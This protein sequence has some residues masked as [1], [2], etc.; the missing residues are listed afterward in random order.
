MASTIEHSEPST[1]FAAPANVVVVA[2][3]SAVAAYAVAAGAELA[4]IRVFQPTELELTWISDLI[5]AATLGTVTYLWLHLRATRATLSAI[6]RDKLVLD[7]QLSLA[8]DVQRKLLPEL[9]AETPV[10][11]WGA[12]LHPAGKVGGDFYDIVTLGD[13]TVM[14]VLADISGK[15]VPAAMLLAWTRAVFRTLAAE[16]AEPRDLV[17]RMS[18]ALHRDHGGAL[19]LTCIAARFDGRAGTLTYANAG[20]P[21]GLVVGADATAMLDVG[22][23]PAGL[24][25]AASF[26]QEV[27]QLRT[28]DLVVLLTDGVTEALPATPE[29]PVVQLLRTLRA[30]DG[31]TA[32][33]VICDELIA[34]AE[35]GPGP[36]QVS[37]WQDDRTVVAMRYLGNWQ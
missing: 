14:F 29:P 3:V 1:A 7:T 8:A 23:P 33:L 9:P 13:G 21:A 17:A 4:L 19:Y 18:R 37:D 30:L 28:G 34:L 26:T 20:H 6:E 15:G 2:A 16:Q 35:R 10:A 24:F 11:R 32:P 36:E 31:H 5:L 12:R 22:G 25:P 27:L